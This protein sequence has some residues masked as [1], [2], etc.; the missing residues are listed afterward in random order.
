MSSAVGVEVSSNLSD[1][2]CGCPAPRRRLSHRWATTNRFMRLGAIP[3][4]P[5][6]SF[7]PARQQGHGHRPGRTKMPVAMHA[8]C[9]SCGP[10]RRA[11]HGQAGRRR[12]RA[13]G[14][15]QRLGPDV[16]AAVERLR[17]RPGGEIRSLWFLPHPA[18]RGPTGLLGLL[19]LVRQL[20][21]KLS[22]DPVCILSP[23][24]CGLPSSAVERN[25]AVTPPNGVSPPHGVVIALG[26]GR[27]VSHHPAPCRHFCRPA[28]RS[29]EHHRT[30]FGRRLKEQLVESRHRQTRLSLDVTQAVTDVMDMSR[31]LVRRYE[32]RIPVGAPAGWPYW[33]DQ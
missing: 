20:T 27:R 4:W 3:G 26:V 21:V 23:V 17:V 6:W 18:S 32:K 11:Q 16:P 8:W 14:N 22:R 9:S 28:D 15:S 12:P 10:I 31:D 19:Q 13:A 7:R 24:V 33:P 25:L 1:E 5:S 30:V 2:S 29:C